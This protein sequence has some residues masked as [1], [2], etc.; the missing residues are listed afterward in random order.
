[1]LSVRKSLPLWL[2]T[3]SVFLLLF[4]PYLFANGMFMD[5][6]LYAAVARNLAEMPDAF[7]NLFNLS[8]TDTL[9]K[10]FYD[11]PPLA[12]WLQAVLFRVLGDSIYVERVYSFITA[13]LC[14]ILIVLIWRIVYEK[15]ETGREVAWLPAFFWSIVPLVFWSFSNNMLENTLAV[16]ALL[17]VYFALKGLSSG[18]YLYIYAGSSL[19]VFLAF[20]AKSF[21]GLF[22]LAT[23]PIYWLVRRD[24]SFPDALKVFVKFIL[25]T[26][27]IFALFFSFESSREFFV[28]NLKAQIIPSM[29]GHFDTVTGK[30]FHLLRRLIKELLPILV[31][32]LIFWGCKSKMRLEVAGKCKR[33]WFWIFLLL[34]VSGSFPIMLSFKQKG[35][36]LVP[37]LSF[38]ALALAV[39][40]QPIVYSVI[41][42]LYESKSSY[43][44]FKWF[45][46]GFLVFSIIFSLSHLGTI[47]RDAD[48]LADSQL[49]AKAI[50]PGQL[51]SSNQSLAVDWNLIGYLARNHKI[52]VDWNNLTDFYLVEKGCPDIPAGYSVLDLPTV[53]Y[54]LFKKHAGASG[55]GE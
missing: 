13:L 2:I 14:F 33:D 46:I 3:I 8:Y 52:S 34:A 6:I 39:L 44:Y 1:M 32:S 5:G 45:S 23:I 43:R 11:Q 12:M 55:M 18:R 49:V 28:Q 15:D 27:A 42:R 37:S 4:F 16:F 9:L 51:V 29:Q 47:R 10:E 22:P 19:S 20:L 53:K 35:Y 31:F 25:C 7:A 30:R 17:A 54:Q 38:Y 26:V 48:K 40:V 36:Y 50:H 21:V 41:H 24:M